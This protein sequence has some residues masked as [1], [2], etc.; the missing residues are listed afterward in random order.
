MCFALA[1]GV[2]KTRLMGSF[3]AYLNIEKK[4]KNFFVL[5][6]NLT[7]YNKLI[8]DFTNTSS[9]KYVFRGI[10]EF[11]HNKPRIIT[12]DNYDSVSQHELFKSQI[13]INV[14]NISKINSETRGGKAPR[15]KRLS[16]YLGESYFNYLAS[17]EDLVLL[18]D[19][20]HHYRATQG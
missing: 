13:H 6:P 15:I 12:G 2:G 4:I 8:D 20:S 16:E 10:G 17:L 9:P 5:A 14:F 7:I 18:M 11:V 3:V 1:T 19:E